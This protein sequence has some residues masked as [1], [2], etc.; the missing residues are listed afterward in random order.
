MHTGWIVGDQEG[1]QNRLPVS[2]IN[3]SGIR[4]VRFVPNTV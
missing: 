3:R 1:V 2:V 4:G